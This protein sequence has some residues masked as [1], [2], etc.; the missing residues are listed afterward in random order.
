MTEKS[1]KDKKHGKQDNPHPHHKQ[2]HEKKLKDKE[3]GKIHGGSNPLNSTNVT[4]TITGTN[5]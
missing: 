2:S 3:L 1:K 4:V 5:D